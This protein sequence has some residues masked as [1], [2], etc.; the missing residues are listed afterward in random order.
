[1]GR[2]GKVDFS[3]L[4]KFEKQL[5]QLEKVDSH[6]LAE[7]LAKELAQR[8]LRRVIQKTPIGNYDKI[9]YITKKNGKLAVFD[10][11]SGNDKYAKKSGGTLKRAWTVGSIK[12]RGDLIEIEIINPVEYAQYVEYGHRT[13]THDGWV[14]GRFMLTDSVREIEQLAPKL[15]EK[16]LQKALEELFNGK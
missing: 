16:R 10:V 8:L 15:V 11:P 9:F 6:K 13:P 4:K 5:E 14:K 12:R 2:W 7:E 3:D 1:M